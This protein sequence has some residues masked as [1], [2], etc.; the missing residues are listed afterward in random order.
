MAVQS[1][2][3]ELKKKAKVKKKKERD[4]VLMCLKQSLTRENLL[5][6]KTKNTCSFLF[7]FFR[8]HSACGVVLKH[9]LRF[10]VFFSDL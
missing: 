1:T 10:T 7:L 6:A 8:G 2:P 4:D 9:F 3:E 5:K